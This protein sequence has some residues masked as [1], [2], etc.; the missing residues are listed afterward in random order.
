M[1]KALIDFLME[2]AERD[3]SL[4]F[5]A[6]D[7]GYSFVEPFK[8]KYPDR[9][10]NAGIA[11]QNM[12]GVAAGLAMTGKN[13]YVYSIIPFL[14]MR[15]FEQIRVDL[16]YQNLP[17]KLFGVGAGYGYGEMGSTHHAIEDIAIMQSLPEMK[18]LAPANRKEA[19][20]L[21]CEMSTIKSPVY[22]R[23]AK[24]DESVMYPAHLI[25]HFGLINELTYGKDGVVITTG[26]VF[27]IGVEVC[28]KLKSVGIVLGLATSPTIKPLDIEF[29]KRNQKAKMLFTIE[30]HSYYGGFG[31]AVAT[32]LLEMQE[33]PSY[34]KA[35]A[36][37]D[38]Y[39]QVVGST[40]Y[41]RKQ[42]ALD[43]DSIVTN[44]KHIM[45]QK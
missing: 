18:V 1:R 36:I 4:Y 16:C 44:I 9:F 45:E 42:A 43:A 21:F 12:I 32:A 39:A 31:M 13:V 24:N 23:L 30:E 38:I 19:Y 37:Q 29:L 10:M 5:I 41:L 35:F 14:V 34:F 22:C 27:D 11:E 2:E 3:P 33:R 20:E 17:V 6:G 25:T 15:A 8:E 28:E 7:V 40:K 26:Q